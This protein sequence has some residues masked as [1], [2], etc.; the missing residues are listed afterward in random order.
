MVG[1]AALKQCR[2]ANRKP[3]F[4]GLTHI[5]SGEIAKVNLHTTPLRI[6]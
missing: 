4:F 5:F 1:S 3:I 2:S 6:F